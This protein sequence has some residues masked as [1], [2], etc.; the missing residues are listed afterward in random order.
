M[1]L[2][3]EHRFIIK[4]T[5]NEIFLNIRSVYCISEVSIMDK[6]EDFKERLRT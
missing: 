2:E 3:K 4:I 5:K 1:R 6:C